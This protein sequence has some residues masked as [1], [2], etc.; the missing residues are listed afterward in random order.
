MN[1]TLI[2]QSHKLFFAWYP[3][4]ESKYHENTTTIASHR[5]IEE[6]GRILMSES[7]E[8]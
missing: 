5:L 6:I 1:M 4:K 2:Q 3:L 8:G 7:E